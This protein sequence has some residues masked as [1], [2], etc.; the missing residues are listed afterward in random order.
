MQYILNIKTVSEANCSAHWTIKKKRHD[1]QKGQVKYF[2][3]I[4]RPNISFPCTIKLTRLGK[5]KLESDNLPVS[6]KYIRDSI[7]SI[8][9]PEKLIIVKTR[10]GKKYVNPGRAD[11]DDLITWL[12]DQEISEKYGV[13]LEIF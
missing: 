6:M 13:K 3:L 7:A 12:Y 9:F 11:D 4:N 5:K 10:K 2:W 1:T 8:I